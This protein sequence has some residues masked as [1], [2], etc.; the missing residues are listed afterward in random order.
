V[1]K[2]D[3]RTYL[4]F[5]ADQTDGLDTLLNRLEQ[6][7][8]KALFFFPASDLAQHDAQIR[9]VLIGGHAVGLFLSGTTAQELANSAAEGNRLLR[10]IACTGTYTVLLPDGT[11]AQTAAALRDG[12]LLVWQTDVD[13]L[14]NGQSVSTRASAVKGNV[15][16]YSRAVYILSD[17]STSAS[18]LMAR[19]IPELIEDQ[20]D[21]RLAVETEI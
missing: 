4:A 21:L 16:K 17:C 6:H 19:L 8:L 2:S 10:Q 3:V 9:R 20:Y 14:P 7:Q 13:A 11:D 5:R 12:G 18:A 15:E 1:D